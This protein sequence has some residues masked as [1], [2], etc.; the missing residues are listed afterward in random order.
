MG[1]ALCTLDFF[2][3]CFFL[4]LFLAELDGLV[5]FPTRLTMQLLMNILPE[6]RHSN[7]YI[8]NGKNCR[9]GTNL[10]NSIR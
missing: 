4:L 9:I 5:F 10:A 6:Y 3:F 2:L 8:W 7:I 1:I